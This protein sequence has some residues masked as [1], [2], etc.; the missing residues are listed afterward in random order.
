[1]E[2][3][4]QIQAIQNVKK[5]I[6]EVSILVLVEIRNQ[7][8][9]KCPGQ[10][11]LICF[12]PCFGGNQKSNSIFWKTITETY[13]FQSLFWWKSEIK[14]TARSFAG[15]LYEFQSLF[16]WK[17]E[18]KSSSMRSIM[19]SGISFNPCFGGNQKSNCQLRNKVELSKKCFNPCFGGNQKSNM[20]C[21]IVRSRD[22]EFQSLFWW[23]SEI[24]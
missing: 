11:S 21:E 17:S 6:T 9:V 24:K 5:I 20:F 1:M 13:K 18:I 4:N 2:I 19:L 7:I 16:W 15:Q 3:R 22:L 8:I 12:N 23:K 14:S 10:V